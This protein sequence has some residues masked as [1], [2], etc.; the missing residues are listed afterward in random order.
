MKV[1]SREDMQK[2]LIQAKEE[3]YYEL[4]L[5]EFATGLRLG[6]LMALQWD[7]VDLVTGELRINKQ[8]NLVGSKLVISEP[9]TKAAVRTLILP[10]SVR[11]VL[12]E[13]KTRVNSRWLFPSPK[14]KTYR[15][16]PRQSGDGS[17]HCWSMRDVGKCAFR[18]C[19]ILL[20]PMPWPMEWTSRRC[21]S[22]LTMCPAP[23]H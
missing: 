14:R 18:I 19:A 20:Q 9:K 1:L 6:E 2:V 21:P 17:T 5:L 16:F 7:D 10:P 8:V 4:F 15:L 11:K 13:Y 23:P 22:S 3:N 12:A